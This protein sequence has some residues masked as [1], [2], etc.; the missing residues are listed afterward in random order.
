[1][2]VVAKK[3]GKRSFTATLFQAVDDAGEIKPRGSI[4]ELSPRS[5]LLAPRSSVYLRVKQK[6]PKLYELP[7]LC[8]IIRSFRDMSST[9]LTN[10]PNFCDIYWSAV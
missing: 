4:K 6:T 1:M 8:E 3:T 9:L 2:V 10:S 7:S 5:L